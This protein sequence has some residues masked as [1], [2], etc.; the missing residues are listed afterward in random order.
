MILQEIRLTIRL[1]RFELYA[2]GTA[3]VVLAIAGFVGSAYVDGLRP[4]P[5]CMAIDGSSPPSC[6]PGV[7]AE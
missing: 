2:F 7:R 6:E 1:H 3:L 5:E 4:A